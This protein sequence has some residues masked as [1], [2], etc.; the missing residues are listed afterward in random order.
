MAGSR[1]LLTSY[2]TPSA[3]FFLGIVSI[4]LLL[5]SEQL[6]Q[7]QR[8]DFLIADALMDVQ[9]HLATFHLRLEE[10]M[11]GKATI[12]I[13]EVWGELD[14]AVRIVEVILQGGEAEHSMLLN[15]LEDGALRA[16]AES[17]RSSLLEFRQIA[18]ERLRKKAGIGSAIE[19]RFDNVFVTILNKTFE[20]ERLLEAENSLFVAKS[21]RLFNGILFTW[22]IVIAA[23]VVGTWSSEM[24]RR[25]AKDDLLVAN[26]QLQSQAEELIEHREHLVQLVGERTAE[27]TAANE[28]LSKTGSQ[29]RHLSQ[30]LLSAQ[31]LERKRISMELH[32]ELGQ[33][34][35]VIKLR[36]RIIEQK[37]GEDQGAIKQDCEQLLA[38]MNQVV[39]DVRRISLNLSPTVLE[40]LGLTASLR[41]LLSTF[42]ANSAVRITSDIEEIDSL[43]SDN[44]WI[45]IYRIIQE[46]FT[47]IGKHSGAQKVS[48]VIRRSGGDVCF[49]IEDSGKGFTPDDTVTQG[50][51]SKGLGLRIMNE[52]VLMLGGVFELWSREGKG[53]RI[54]FR[55]PLEEEGT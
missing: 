33:S 6:S 36:L 55:I 5:W 38:Y 25:R 52:R 53:T 15:Q 41:W 39:E 7:R 28:S 46:A 50:S 32:D 43:I 24:G 12:N 44:K 16:R 51:S 34:L 47:N 9:M 30:Q 14:K 40:E 22:I 11:D 19:E 21:G 13:N 54:T 35:N 49:A 17:I 37:L 2:W 23:A 45:T 8:A 31:E 18:F 26:R 42:A 1:K 48:V 29:I 3:V 4:V 10:H 27:L 20:L